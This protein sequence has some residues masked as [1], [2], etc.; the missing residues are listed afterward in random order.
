[1]SLI[2]LLWDLK[3]VKHVPQCLVYNKSSE[4]ITTI[5]TY[6]ISVAAESTGIIS[7]AYEILSFECKLLFLKYNYK[8]ENHASMTCTTLCTAL[9]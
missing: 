6:K 7:G 8:W 3:Y 1:M 9:S 2:E 5:C 4:I